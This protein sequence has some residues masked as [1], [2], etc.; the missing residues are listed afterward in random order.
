MSLWTPVTTRNCLSGHLSLQTTV[1]IVMLYLRP[2]LKAFMIAYEMYFNGLHSH[3]QPCMTACC[4]TM[5]L[6]S[7]HVTRLCKWVQSWEH[8]SDIDLS[9]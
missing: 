2:C 8:V 3:M 6:V 5:F 9:E 4:I 1:S 7:R